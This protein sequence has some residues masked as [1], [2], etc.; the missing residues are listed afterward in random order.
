MKNYLNKIADLSKIEFYLCGPPLMVKTC[1]NM[2]IDIGVKNKQILF[3][4]F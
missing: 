3:D 4:A 1:R 2:L